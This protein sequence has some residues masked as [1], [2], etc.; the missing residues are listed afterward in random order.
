MID[1]TKIHE[2]KINWARFASGFNKEDSLKGT[3]AIYDHMLTLLDGCSDEDVTFVPVDPDAHDPYA[4]EANDEA[5]AWTLGHVIVHVTASNEES[6]FLAAELARGVEVE[7]HRSRYETH[8]ET[9]TTI[10]QL[11]QRLEESR[12]MLLSSLEI[13]PD[14]PHLENFYTATSGLKITPIMR[15]LLGL[16]HCDEHLP[17][18]AEIL[19]QA[20]N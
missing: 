11:R 13:W 16:A 19:R 15:F 18:M 6:A 7:P 3:L 4:E 8:W 5:L 20:Q 12:R 10:A 17:Q 1:F 14:E 9:V 2:K